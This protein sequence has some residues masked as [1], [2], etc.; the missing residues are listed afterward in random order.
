MTEF[1]EKE[2]DESDIS[3]LEKAGRGDRE[4]FGRLYARL[5][6]PLYSLA[7]QMLGDRTEAEDALLEGMEA[8]WKQAPRFDG[9]K[10]APFTWAVMVF[11]ARVI[12]RARR[13]ATQSRLRE[14]AKEH[15]NAEYSEASAREATGFLASREE[16]EIVRK[17]VESLQADQASMLRWS[18]FEG[19]THQEIAD[20]TGRPLG[21]VKTVIRRSLIELRSKILGRG[22][23]K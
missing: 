7:V 6:T 5:S 18:F 4:A 17:A 20:R 2:I 3:L 12:D 15:T 1:R 10:A 9:R 22:Y 16:W 23:G 21:T 11:R 13:R 19:L 14:K 8:I